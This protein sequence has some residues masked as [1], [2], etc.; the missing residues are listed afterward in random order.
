MA[1]TVASV[2]ILRIPRTW[3]RVPADGLQGDVYH[4]NEN[5]RLPK[6]AR[7]ARDVWASAG[8]IAQATSGEE[9]PGKGSLS[10]RLT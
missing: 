9:K 6:Y 7:H 4:R 1:A 5:Y 2:D 3:H 8:H 10:P